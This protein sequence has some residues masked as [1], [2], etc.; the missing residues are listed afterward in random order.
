[1]KIIS[2]DQSSSRSLQQGMTVRHLHVNWKKNHRC[3]DAGLEFI[4]TKLP[5][6]LINLQTLQHF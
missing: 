5:S 3:I 1:M 4:I 2:S 6:E